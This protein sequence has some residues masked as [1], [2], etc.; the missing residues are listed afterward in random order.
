[1]KTRA[2]PAESI[3]S[4]GTL[5]QELYTMKIPFSGD[6]TLLASVHETRGKVVYFNK[7]TKASD[8]RVMVSNGDAAELMEKAIEHGGDRKLNISGKDMGLTNYHTVGETKAL[9]KKHDV[10]CFKGSRGSVYLAFVTAE[11]AAKGKSKATKKV[12]ANKDAITF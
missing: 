5:E 2:P 8:N 10:M 3:G 7:A 1:M 11:T 4:V 9:L 12:K 6:V